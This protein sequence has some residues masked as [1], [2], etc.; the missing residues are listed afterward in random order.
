MKIKTLG[1]CLA[2]SVLGSV[3]Q[4]WAVGEVL[5][6]ET[7]GTQ[8]C[9]GKA[10]AEL[11]PLSAPPLWF[12][13]DSMTQITVFWDAALTIPAMVLPVQLT[14]LADDANG[15][16]QYAVNALYGP[17]KSGYIA[18]NGVAKTDKSK[19]MLRY[20]NVTYIRQMLTDFC[21]ANGR[22]VGRVVK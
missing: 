5:K 14:P 10:P 2:L 21:S 15:R 1:I 12:K 7:F 17:T 3:S 20:F 16:G 8:Y 4:A 13:V 22:M 9:E 19:T 18:L 6:V 11:D